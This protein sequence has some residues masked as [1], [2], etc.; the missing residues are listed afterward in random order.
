MTVDQRGDA[1]GA[2]ADEQR[3]RY[4]ELLQEL[5]TLLP[6]VQ[7]LFAFLLTAPFAARFE[8]LDTV[9]RHGHAVA[10][11]SAALA[12]LLFLAP[13]SYHR[14][15]PRQERRRRLRLGIALT[16]AGMV[17]LAVSIGASVFVV[18]RFVYGN[19][20][21]VAMTAGLAVVVAILWYALPLRRRIRG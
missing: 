20:P 5:R 15:A 21:A 17:A 12:T 8:Q 19:T 2:S 10:M 4:S 14:I 11:V 6:G 13:T 3:E 9:G 1:A 7:V 18:T 16:I